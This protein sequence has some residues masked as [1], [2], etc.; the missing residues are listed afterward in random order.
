MEILIPGLILVALMVYVSTKIKK[1]AAKA[2]ETEF[3]ETDEFSLTKPDGFLNPLS[4]NSAFAFE[5]FTIDFGAEPHQH[6]KQASIE[7]TEHEGST[8]DAV[9][10]EIRQNSRKIVSE[11]TDDGAVLIEAE[12]DLDRAVVDVFYKVTEGRDKIWR[13]RALVLPEHKD[14]YLRRIEKTLESFTLK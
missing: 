6:L 3:I 10:G 2:Y 5:A 4:D 9:C 1:N 7:L 8:L 13:L 12:H 11:R 14:E